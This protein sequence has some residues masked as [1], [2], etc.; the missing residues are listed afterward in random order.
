M[1]SPIA[2]LQ[3]HFIH[4]TALTLLFSIGGTPHSE[5]DFFFSK[6]KGYQNEM[7]FHTENPASHPTGANCWILKRFSSSRRTTRHDS[8]K[9]QIL[10]NKKM[11]ENFYQVW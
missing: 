5:W 2:L 9:E 11:V 8:V 3:A 4:V 10:S 6:V 1:H 7:S